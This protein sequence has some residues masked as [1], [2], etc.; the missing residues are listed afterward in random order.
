[1]NPEPF[2]LLAV[3]FVPMLFE[4]RRSA[5]NERALRAAGAIEPADDVYSLMQV[6][7]PLCFL[8]M[9]V[10]AWARA[11]SVGATALA[12]SLIFISAKALKYWAIGTLGDRW[13]F[14]VLVPPGSA[15]TVRGPYRI[16]RHPNYVA[17][18]GE[19]AGFALLARAPVAGALSLAAFGALLVARVRVEER[20]LGLRSR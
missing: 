17:V 9:V 20:A 19:L 1:M 14:R 10:E 2:L 3:G 15:R 18:V 7:Y 11:T 6:A 13:T 16:L 5:A 8:A 12:G 4:A